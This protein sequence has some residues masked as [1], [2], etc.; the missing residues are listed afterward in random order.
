MWERSGVLKKE[1]MRDTTASCHEFHIV[2]PQE[3]IESAP[4]CLELEAYTNGIVPMSHKQTL[5]LE[6][7]FQT[8]LIAPSNQMQQRIHLAGWASTSR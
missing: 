7:L 4:L 6:E 2:V 1:G 5:Y 3:I 8:V